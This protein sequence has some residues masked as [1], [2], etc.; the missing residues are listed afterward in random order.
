MSHDTNSLFKW[1]MFLLQT[2]FL[3]LL[4]SRV[5]V[6]L[7]FTG[8]EIILVYFIITQEEDDEEEEEKKMNGK[9]DY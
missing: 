7:G 2:A 8:D 4:A 1:L 9:E 5:L 6:Y 3:T